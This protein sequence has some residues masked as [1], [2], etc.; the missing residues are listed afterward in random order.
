MG[1]RP[2]SWIE[3]EPADPS[4]VRRLE[5]ELGLPPELCE[6]LVRRGHAGPESAKRFLRPHLSGLHPPGLLPEMERAVARI[7][8]ALGEGETIL[9]HGDY[10]ADGTCAAALLTLG[11]RELGARVHSFVPHRTRDGYGLGAAG[12]ARAE[13]VGAS[14]VVTADCGV[15][16][17]EAVAVA[18]RAGRDVVVTDHHRPSGRLPDAVAV[19]NPVRE[20]SRYP[21]GGLAGTGVAFKLLGALGR[22]EGLPE[23]ALNRHLD[24]VALGSVADMVP[25]RDENRILVRAGLRALERTANPGLRALLR[26]TGLGTGRELRAE[27]LAYVLAPRVNAAG[28][29]GEAET[30]LRLLLARDPGEAARLARELDAHNTARRSE[31]RRVQREA[32][33]ELR[34]RFDPEDDSAVV[35]WGE[36]WHPGVVG[37]VASRIVEQVYRPT[38]VVALEEETGKGSGRSVPGFHLHRAL[39]ECEPLL[40]RYGG[41]R[42]AAGLEIRRG[43]LELFAERLGEIA[44][45]TLDPEDLVRTLVVDLVLPLARADEELH[46]WLA[47]L[48]PFGRENERPVL[49]SRGVTIDRVRTVGAAGRHLRATLVGSDGTRIP[50]VGF[51]LGARADGLGGGGRWDVA[52][53]LVDDRYRGRRRL[54][55]RI[56]DL[57][58]SGG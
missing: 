56:R 22:E 19:V 12:L 27:H 37:I 40:E 47:H 8:T 53:E 2:V 18:E 39:A 44:E 45:R 31:D 49:A 28:R 38:V 35:V 15:T 24:L 10:D 20:Q 55:A 36:G 29:V 41:H 3:P 17:V 57:R 54:E 1:A 33:E 9:V 25:L 21:F 4:V 16:A 50:A 6:I 52:Y 32:E 46:R 23:E 11:L 30:A 43:K 26:E 42:M 48:A 7:R 34:R 14:L 13:E 51:G 5:E 58:P